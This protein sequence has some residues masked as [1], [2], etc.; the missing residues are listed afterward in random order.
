V[1]V[2]A[3]AGGDVAAEL[4]LLIPLSSEFG[5]NK[6]VKARFRPCLEPF[7][8]GKSL[9]P[10]KLFLGVTG[11]DGDVAAELALR[12]PAPGRAP[13]FCEG[14]EGHQARRVCSAG[15]DCLMCGLDSLIWH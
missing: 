2:E 6:T 12:L 9:K 1:L 8:R 13:P 15:L 5:T 10:C 3:G 7:F 14:K 11:A 4:A